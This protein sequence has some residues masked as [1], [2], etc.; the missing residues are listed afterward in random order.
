MIH[1]YESNNVNSDFMRTY[2]N[3]CYLINLKL[4][5]IYIIIEICYCNIN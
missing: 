5:C 3:V 2:Y 4:L 1:Y